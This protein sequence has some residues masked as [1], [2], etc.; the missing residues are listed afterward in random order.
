MPIFTTALSSSTGQ[1]TIE[2]SGTI[3]ASGFL[4][5]GPIKI[6]HSGSLTVSQNAIA[7]IKDIEDA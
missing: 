2:L 4:L 1:G 5:Y 7:K 6:R 3:Q